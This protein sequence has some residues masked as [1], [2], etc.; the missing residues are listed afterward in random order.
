MSNTRK[1][2]SSDFQNTEKLVEKTRR[3][4]CFETNFE[5]QNHFSKPPSREAISFVF[6]SRII[7]ISLRIIHC[8]SHGYIKSPVTYQN[9]DATTRPTP[10]QSTNTTHNKNLKNPRKCSLSAIAKPTE[11]TIKEEKKKKQ[12]FKLKQPYAHPFK[13]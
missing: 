3:S 10:I 7:L 12:K 9:N 1:S 5:V 8:R 4:Q 13:G 2:V 11:D 6:S